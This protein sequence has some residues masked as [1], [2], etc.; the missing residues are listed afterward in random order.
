MDGNWVR[1]RRCHEDFEAAEVCPTCGAPYQLRGPQ[2]HESADSFAEL[3]AGTEFAPPEPPAPPLVG[4]RRRNPTPFIVGGAALVVFALL[5]AAVT[6]AWNGLPQ[7]T[8]PPAIVRG[9]AKPTAT[10]SPLPDSVVATIAQLSDPGFTAAVTIQSR[11]TID[12]RVTGK[13]QY[14]TVVFDGYLSGANETGKY[15]LNTTSREVTV[16]GGIAYS[17]ASGGATWAGAPSTPTYLV[18]RPLLGLTKP[19]MLAL[20][21]PETRDGAAVIHLRSTAYWV[22]ELNR[23][24][25][26]DLSGV[27]IKPDTFRLDL[28]TAPDGT[29]VYAEFS[30]VTAAL[31][32]TKLIDVAATWSFSDVGIAHAIADPLA[33]P[34]PS[35]SPSPDTKAGP[36]Q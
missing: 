9:T 20:V 22:P 16:F 6:G 18:L 12:A 15:T 33:T 34:T 31:D 4:P 25:L 3:Y 1:C 7:P 2:P 21:G 29:P 35:P 17:R 32:G 28:W 24:A 26:M 30:A 8:A 27:G 36:G 19:A 13:S 5:L 11:A 23:M 10:P 14:G